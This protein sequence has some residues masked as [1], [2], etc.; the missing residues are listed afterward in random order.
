MV[1]DGALIRCPA[2]LSQG[3]RCPRP[4]LPRHPPRISGVG[5]GPWRRGIVCNCYVTGLF[6]LAG[7]PL[8]PSSTIP[9]GPGRKK[10]ARG[11]ER[12]AGGS[13]LAGLRQAEAKRI[14]ILV[15]IVMDGGWVDF[16]K[17][18]LSPLHHYS[19]IHIPCVSFCL[20][21]FSTLHSGIRLFHSRKR[22][23]ASDNPS[24]QA[25]SHLHGGCPIR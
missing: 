19:F 16:K 17:P 12:A 22:F 13:R 20:P 23:F 10:G 3:Q 18:H 11:S 5:N 1:Q 7:C 6:R 25:T 4:A 14:G 9:S 2:G 15:P 21:S 24:Q 8:P